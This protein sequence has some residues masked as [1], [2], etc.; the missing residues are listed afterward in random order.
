MH[1]HV[2]VV[3]GVIQV[4]QKLGLQL[5]LTLT[6]AH[7]LVNS[8]FGLRFAATDDKRHHLEIKFV[9]FSILVV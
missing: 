7:L 2:V 9:L 5:R 6:T 4:A 1:E 3:H 8:R